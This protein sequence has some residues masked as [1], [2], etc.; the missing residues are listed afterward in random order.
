MDRTSNSPDEHINSLP[1]RFGDD[2]RRLDVEISQ[3]MEGRDRALY[4]GR[5]WGG[6]EQTIIGYGDFEYT[7]SKGEAVNWFLVGLAAQK[8]H[9]SLYVNAVEDGG[10]LIRRYAGRLGK[11]K[12]GSAVVTFKSLDAVDFDVLMELVEHA[13]RTGA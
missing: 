11:A 7:N 1:A 9:I 4:Q 8:D 13:N 3:R 10:Y 6:T 5:F 12:S 2:L